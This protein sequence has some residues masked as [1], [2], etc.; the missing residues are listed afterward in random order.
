MDIYLCCMY[1]PSFLSFS[2]FLIWMLGESFPCSVNM[3]FHQSLSI[4]F[5]R[6]MTNPITWISVICFSLRKF[7][8]DLFFIIVSLPIALLKYHSNWLSLHSFIY[9]HVII[10][11]IFYLLVFFH[12]NREH[13]KFSF[14][15]L[16]ILYEV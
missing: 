5:A 7:F 16:I 4:D 13:L 9:K 14:I 6:N 10:S 1:L 15:S 11:L 2:S 8:F 3:F 12:I